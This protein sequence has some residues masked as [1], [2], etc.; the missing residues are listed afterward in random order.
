MISIVYLVSIVFSFLGIICA[1]FNFHLFIYIGAIFSIV[2]HILGK[3]TGQ[4]KSFNTLFFTIFI[5]LLIS[6]LMQNDLLYIICICLCIE[7]IT[8]LIG[9]IIFVTIIR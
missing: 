7:N 4:L 9:G 6:Y 2:E 5:G 8:N 3:I 1:F